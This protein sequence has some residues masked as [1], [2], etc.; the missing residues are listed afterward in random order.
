[1][2]I[3]FISLFSFYYDLSFKEVII[4][5]VIDTIYILIMFLLLTT[6]KVKNILNKIL[7]K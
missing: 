6:N 1:M 4:A 3:C 2:G 7:M 5:L